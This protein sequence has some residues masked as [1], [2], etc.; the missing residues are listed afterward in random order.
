MFILPLI[1]AAIRVMSGRQDPKPMTRDEL[2]DAMD[3]LQ[4]DYGV[5]N[6]EQL[7]WKNS[8]VDTMKAIGIDSTLPNRRVLAAEFG[9]KGSFDGTA[10]QNLWLHRQLQDRF[11]CGEIVPRSDFPEQ[12]P[13]GPGSRE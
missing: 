8:V 6:S 3:Q 4:R 12:N 9:H 7:D 11:A 5:R 13:D 1:F 2:H 10:E